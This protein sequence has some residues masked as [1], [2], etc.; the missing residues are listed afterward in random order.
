M[1]ILENVYPR[2]PFGYVVIPNMISL[3]NEP[4]DDFF[5][6]VRKYWLEETKRQSHVTEVNSDFFFIP[7]SPS[8]NSGSDTS[9]SDSE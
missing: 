3:M 5:G 2:D 7:S 8:G 1:S 4:E 9:G 6:N